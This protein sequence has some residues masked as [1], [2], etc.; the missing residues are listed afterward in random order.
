[1]Y[2][3]FY[4]YF[5]LISHLS[6]HDISLSLVLHY[7]Q[8]RHQ[9]VNINPDAYQ[10]RVKNHVNSGVNMSTHQQ[11]LISVNKEF[12]FTNTSLTSS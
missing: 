6:T 5:V 3:V 9:S 11:L 12:L 10:S 4:Y 7:V 8:S 2:H 1:M